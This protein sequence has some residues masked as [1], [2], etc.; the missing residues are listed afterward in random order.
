MATRKRKT[1]EK[2][3]L[4][5]VAFDRNS[6]KKTKNRNFDAS[7]TGEKDCHFLICQT[8]PFI[9]VQAPSLVKSKQTKG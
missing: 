2:E 7:E 3:S 4:P 5:C 8:G 9:F 6:K 1:K